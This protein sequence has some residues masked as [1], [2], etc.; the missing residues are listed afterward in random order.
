MLLYMDKDGRQLKHAEGN[1][2]DKNHSTEINVSVVAVASCAL[3][4][5]HKSLSIL[6]GP[7]SLR[8]GLI[9]FKLAANM[10]AECE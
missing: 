8:R 5:H 7:L 1:T 10:Y 3:A 4:Y 9:I 2:V 6:L